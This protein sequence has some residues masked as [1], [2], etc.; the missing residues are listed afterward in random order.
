MTLTEGHPRGL[1]H[2]EPMPDKGGD[3]CPLGM[4]C[5]TCLEESRAGGEVGG[6]LCG[7]AFNRVS[8]AQMKKPTSGPR[9]P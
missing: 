8:R 5:P 7:F 4:M 9:R 2:F 6:T 3:N 1:G